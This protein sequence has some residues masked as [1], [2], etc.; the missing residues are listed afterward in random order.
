MWSPRGSSA[1]TT[2]AVAEEPATKPRSGRFFGLGKGKNSNKEEP[3]PDV[4]DWAIEMRS[5][6]AAAEEQRSDMGEHE[7]QRKKRRWLLLQRALSPTND[8]GEDDGAREDEKAADRRP[9]QAAEQPVSAETEVKSHGSNSFS[10]FKQ[11]PRQTKVVFRQFGSD[12]TE[13]MKVEQLDEMP[14]PESPDHVLVKVQV[15]KERDDVYFVSA[16]LKTSY[17]IFVTPHLLAGF[18]RYIE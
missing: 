6:A 1:N 10:T 16:S 15:R 4:S 17:L 13:V 8:E 12:P 18:N 14:V 7:E 2:N 3:Q 5:D 9:T 11:N